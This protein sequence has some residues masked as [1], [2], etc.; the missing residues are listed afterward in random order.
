MTTAEQQLK[1]L[2]D[3]IGVRERRAYRRSIVAALIPFALGALWIAYSYYKVEKYEQR[4]RQLNQKIEEL[5]GEV[6]QKQQTRDELNSKLDN[7][8]T[9]IENFGKL[10]PQLA[11]K[12]P[13]L[14]R[15]V[16]G[17]IE[18]NPDAANI[19]PR[20]DI[21]PRDEQQRKLAVQLGEELERRGY[22]VQI[23]KRLATIGPN[24]AQV[25]FFD[26]TGDKGDE[27]ELHEAELIAGLLRKMGVEGV[28]AW[29][30]GGTPS[31][32]RKF[33]VWFGP[34]SPNAR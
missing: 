18:A 15:Q 22:I 27:A 31:Q 14:I 26:Y 17:I 3:D 9:T 10:L 4:I 8:K 1:S 29:N 11:E 5:D 16:S 25:R 21:H 6:K 7:L 13:E 30:T 12:D 24:D 33:E 23:D 19:I 32:R 34:P 2:L 20:I 28:H